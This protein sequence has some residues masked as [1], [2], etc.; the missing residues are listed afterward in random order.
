MCLM[1]RGGVRCIVDWFVFF[2]FKQ[3]TAYEIYQCDWSSD[4]CSSDLANRSIFV[5]AQVGTKAHSNKGTKRRNL[6]S[7]DLFIHMKHLKNDIWR[8]FPGRPK[9]RLRQA[10]PVIWILS[11]ELCAYVPLSL[12]A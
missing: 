12:C 8:T 6:K 4:V 7:N 11:S 1:G 5:T 9:C 2:F 10:V 3:K